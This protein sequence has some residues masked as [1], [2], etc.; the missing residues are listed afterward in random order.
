MAP[1]TLVIAIVAT[2]LLFACPASSATLTDRPSEYA[3]PG[4]PKG[5]VAC[6]AYTGLHS[7]YRRYASKQCSELVAG[8]LVF[9]AHGGDQDRVAFLATVDIPQGCQISINDNTWTGTFPAEGTFIVWTTTAPVPKGTVVSIGA[10]TGSGT[11][12]S[13]VA[14]T[15][16][17][18]TGGSN[19]AIMQLS[20]GGSTVYAYLAQAPGTFLAA[21]TTESGGFGTSLQG[22]GL[23][24]GQTAVAITPSTDWGYYDR[25]KGTSFA[26]QAAALATINDGANW[27]T[28][29]GGNHTAQ[30]VADL[31]PMT[32]A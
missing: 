1:R 28:N 15:G 21:V 9:V 4:A 22:T 17:G 18:S 14:S 25:S 31:T 23:V 32:I 30:E 2:L 13:V 11:P 3:Y 8:D 5:H 6:V 7:L 16:Q 27:I 29:V 20:S 19:P 12:T 24:A 26:S 10:D